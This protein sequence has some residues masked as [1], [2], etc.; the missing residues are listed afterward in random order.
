MVDGEEK[1]FPIKYGSGEDDEANDTAKPDDTKAD[2]AKSEEAE[3]ESKPDKRSEPADADSETEG[4]GRARRAVIKSSVVT[5][6]N[7]SFTQIKRK[8]FQISDYMVTALKP[9]MLHFGKVPLFNVKLFLTINT[10]H[11]NYFEKD[12]QRQ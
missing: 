8:H 6:M 2:D 3:P 7:D 1:E 9:K 5:F 11:I 12:W 4:G 10:F